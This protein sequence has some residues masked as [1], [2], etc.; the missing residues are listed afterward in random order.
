MT[1][2]K[3][4]KVKKSDSKKSDGLKVKR[5]LPNKDFLQLLEEVVELEVEVEDLREKV[6]ELAVM[7]MEQRGVIEYLEHKLEGKNDESA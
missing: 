1:N 7:L 5:K 3:E 4:N 6:I 2:I